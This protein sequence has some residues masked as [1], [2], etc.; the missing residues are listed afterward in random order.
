MMEQVLDDFDE[1]AIDAGLGDYLDK[2]EEQVETTENSNDTEDDIDEDTLDWLMSDSPENIKKMTEDE[3]Y[4]LFE[5]S[6][7]DGVFAQNFKKGVDTMMSFYGPHQQGIGGWNQIMSGKVSPEV[8]RNMRANMKNKNVPDNKLVQTYINETSYRLSNTKIN[9]DPI[10]VKGITKAALE[11]NID[12]DILL[13]VASFE[14]NGN[15]KA[16]SPSGKHYGLFQVNKN[17]VSNPSLLTDGYNSAKIAIRHNKNQFKNGK[18]DY[19][20]WGTG[21]SSNP[22]S[23]FGYRPTGNIPYSSD[24]SLFP[25]IK[26]PSSLPLSTGP[27]TDILSKVNKVDVIGGNIVGGI[28]SL[29]NGKRQFQEIAGQTASDTIGVISSMIAEKKNQK[30][31]YNQLEKLYSNEVYNETPLNYNNKLEQAWN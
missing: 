9:L 2:S 6:P 23:S 12:P 3:E 26:F 22:N 24:E 29:I 8:A 11:S 15:N 1:M 30:E 19:N 5:T 10:T 7:E 27:K 4:D 18:L 28:N 20:Q 13:R 14:S 17:Y 25:S 31:F 21:L 16:V